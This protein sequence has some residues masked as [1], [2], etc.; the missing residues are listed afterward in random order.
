MTDEK[1]TLNVLLIRSVKSKSIETFK[2]A[3]RITLSAIFAT[4]SISGLSSRSLAQTESADSV[5]S[6]ESSRTMTEPLAC[7]TPT[8]AGSAN[9][10]QAN[11]FLLALGYGSNQINSIQSKT[12]SHSGGT[13]FA[14]HADVMDFFLKSKAY[15]NAEKE[16]SNYESMNRNQL[17]RN[18][19]SYLAVKKAK[20]L[21]LLIYSESCM[22]DQK[23]SSQIPQSKVI[24]LADLM[25]DLMAL[26]PRQVLSKL[27]QEAFEKNASMDEKN[28]KSAL[29]IDQTL[30]AP[31]L[32][33]TMRAHTEDLTRQI[34]VV[35]YGSAYSQHP[36]SVESIY[37]LVAANIRLLYLD[38]QIGRTAW[39]GRALLALL[40]RD[41]GPIVAK[42][43]LQKVGIEID[44]IIGNRWALP[45]ENLDLHGQLES[46]IGS[47]TSFKD[48]MMNAV[49]SASVLFSETSM[50]NAKSWLL[51][52]SKNLAKSEM[53]D[54]KDQMKGFLS[55]AESKVKKGDTH[56]KDFDMAKLMDSYLRLEE[57]L[58]T[59]VRDPIKYATHLTPVPIVNMTPVL[60]RNINLESA[61][62]PAGALPKNLDLGKKFELIGNFLSA[63]NV[64]D[65]ETISEKGYG[66]AKKIQDR[67]FYRLMNK[68]FSH[69]GFAQLKSAQGVTMSWVADNYPTPSADE[70]LNLPG[71]TYNAGGMRFVGLEQFYKY[72]QHSK[73]AIAQINPHKFRK[74]MASQIRD[75]STLAEKALTDPKSLEQDQN[76]SGPTPK[77][78]YLVNSFDFWPSLTPQVEAGGRPRIIESNELAGSQNNWSILSDSGM[79]LS[80]YFDKFKSIHLSDKSDETWFNDASQAAS[81]KLL[82]F[83]YRGMVFTWIT[84]NGQYYKGAA[85]CSYTGVLAWTLGAG[86][87]PEVNSKGELELDEKTGF[88]K[89]D[90]WAN[91]VKALGQLKKTMLA[92]KGQRSWLVTDQEA[93]KF[94]KLLAENPTLENN[95]KLSSMPIVA[96]SGLAALPFM[97]SVIQVKAPFIDVSQRQALIFENQRVDDQIKDSDYITE[98]SQRNS[99]REEFTQLDETEVR[100]LQLDLEGVFSA[101]EGCAKPGS[102]CKHR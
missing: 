10:Q 90:Q 87:W 80:D 20:E 19:K 69:V 29:E 93:Q 101:K 5:A 14:D 9:Y 26:R 56:L 25:A 18:R 27:Q 34:A 102:I 59:T 41:N 81:D 67:S 58:G 95:F 74:A 38:H 70:E 40:V 6:I 1:S 88:P 85:Y 28:R 3:M 15:F 7:S 35:L 73:I 84:P 31:A 68:G 16:N 71:V 22:M 45:N 78:K 51:N 65:A 8:N 2:P 21:A 83:M 50:Q 53:A 46:A 79:S 12:G 55:L 61:T 99:N 82:E 72:S 98:F 91:I 13:F 54:F 100:G 64:V 94:G 63:L 4:T 23:A 77:R 76:T 42:Q 24:A 62:I 89:A 52:D 92:P 17:E 39:I 32:S 30:I 11:Q 47:L 33:T 75:F 66:I 96:P 49:R 37:N 48:K 44:N 60:T 36:S 57:K 43:A 97:D 86:L